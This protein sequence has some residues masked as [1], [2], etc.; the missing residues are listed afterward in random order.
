MQIME[1][2]NKLA[3]KTYVFFFFLFFNQS[4]DGILHPVPDKVYKGMC[5][6]RRYLRP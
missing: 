1:S 4:T 3:Q 2:I 5:W 6:V